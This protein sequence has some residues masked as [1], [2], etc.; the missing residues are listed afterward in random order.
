VRQDP[1][2]KSCCHPVADREQN[3]AR[4]SAPYVRNV[5][6]QM[7]TVVIPEGN[8]IVG[9]ARPKIPND[10]EELRKPKRLKPFRIGVTTVTNAEFEA[11]VADTGYITEAERFAWSFVFWSDVPSHVSAPLGVGGTEWWR[12]ADGANWL[13]INGPSTRDD[14]W[15]P[16]H[17]V[18][19]VSWNDAKD[20][21]K[22]AGG[23]LPSEAEW[24]HAAR[25][26]QGDVSYPWGEREP[27]DL[28]YMPC[29][30]WQGDFPDRNT[31]ADGYLT[32]AP[33]KSF[34]SNEFGVYNMVGN[35][36]EWTSDMYRIGSMKKSARDRMKS[37]A[38]YRVAKG[39][40]FLCHQSYCW[41]YRIA[42]RSGN[43]P[44]SATTHQ[45]FRIVF[46]C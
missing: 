2:Q 30:I 18:V 11:F 23:R 35:V 20:F 44:D 33:A 16:N 14:A 46:D 4:R 10:G 8:A 31:G 45:G 13:D 36:W 40:S 29:N 42:A 1:S 19:Q 9:T 5:P 41:R 25:G 38:G 37:M 6:F 28:D 32:T 17:P 39:G 3:V 24:E 22:W 34:N 15:H 21:A 26:G 7:D 43:S 27:N 12:R